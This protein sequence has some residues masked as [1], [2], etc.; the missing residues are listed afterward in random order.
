MRLIG[1][2]VG[3]KRIG[4]AVSDPTGVLATAE[5]VLKRVSFAKDIAALAA[6]VHEYDAE[7]FV[8]GMP[9]HLDGRRGEQAELVQQFV[10]RLAPHIN[11]PVFFWDERLSTK[12]A[13]VLL[14]EAGMG[15]ARRAARLDAAAAAVILQNYL[16]HQW[17]KNHRDAQHREGTPVSQ[18]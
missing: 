9:L 14:L 11:V 10:D 18:S 7:G 12:G 15:P 2:D 6:L 8:V 3:N 16:D 4:I 17:Q 13:H 5:R 1:L